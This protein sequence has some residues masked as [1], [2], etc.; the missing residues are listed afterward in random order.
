[1]FMK[2]A[3]DAVPL[4]TSPSLD[5]AVSVALGMTLIIGLYP[6]PFILLAREAVRPFFG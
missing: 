2:K 5:A 1:M 6:Q 3:P 4:A